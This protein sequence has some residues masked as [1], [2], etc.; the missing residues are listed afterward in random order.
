MSIY[1]VYAYLREDGTPYYIGKGK[2]NRAFDPYH[3]V[4]LPEKDRIVFLE[5]NLTNIGAC[6][7]ERRYIRW[8]G[9]KIDGTGILRNITDGG[10]GNSGP[11]TKEWKEKHSK[12][13]LGKNNPMYGK[14]RHWD[15][16]YMQTEEYRQKVS[17]AKKG[18]SN[19]KLKGRVFTEEWRKKLS[20]AAKRRKTI[21]LDVT[22][23]P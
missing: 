23:V 9:K 7:L 1:Y 4:S 15:R 8:Y 3:S 14:K 6:A 2:G 5:K 21:L 11:R 18:K 12:H 13:M 17:A 19:D 16:S 20:D 22:D 10:D